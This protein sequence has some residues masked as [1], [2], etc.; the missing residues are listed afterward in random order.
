MNLRKDSGRNVALSFKNN[1]R[2]RY[3]KKIKQ[4]KKKR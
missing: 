1:F 4:V 2:K 3:F